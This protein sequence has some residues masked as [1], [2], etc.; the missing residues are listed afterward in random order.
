ML[1]FFVAVK[2]N[3]RQL[4]DG[5]IGLFGRQIG[6]NLKE[7]L[8]SS[9]KEAAVGSNPDGFG[10]VLVRQYTVALTIHDEALLL[11]QIREEV[12]VCTYPQASLFIDGDSRDLVEELGGMWCNGAIGCIE[13]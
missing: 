5:Y 3:V 10:T 8:Y 7:P 13:A 6:I 11:G 1:A 9:H 2:Q 12:V 4:Q